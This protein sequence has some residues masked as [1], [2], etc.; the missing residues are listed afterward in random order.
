MFVMLT[1]VSPMSA[2]MTLAGM[3]LTLAKTRASLMPMPNLAIWSIGF[4][5]PVRV[6]CFSLTVNRKFCTHCKVLFALNLAPNHLP[7]AH[8]AVGCADG[9]GVW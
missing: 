7:E 9:E 2:A 3:P 5:M 4:S 1:L 8:F 6:S